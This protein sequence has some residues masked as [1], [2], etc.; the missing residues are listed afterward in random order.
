[1]S[2]GG[3]HFLGVFFFLGPIVAI[4]GTQGKR[5]SCVYRQETGVSFSFL[6]L[7]KWSWCAARAENNMSGGFRESLSVKGGAAL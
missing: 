3:T 2:L 6:K 5:T 7:L 1:M 4:A